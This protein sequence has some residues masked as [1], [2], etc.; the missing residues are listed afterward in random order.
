[1]ARP[2][3]QS[4]A[5]SSDIE[6]RSDRWERFEAAVPSAVISGRRTGSIGKLRHYKQKAA[7]QRKPSKKK[8][9]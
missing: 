2:E 9:R 5:E 6:L 8:A 7:G 1:M 3:R 4:E